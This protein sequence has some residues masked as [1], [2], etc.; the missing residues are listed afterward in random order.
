[1]FYLAAAELLTARAEISDAI[2]GY[3]CAFF[4]HSV[5]PIISACSCCCDLLLAPISRG[6]RR[7]LLRVISSER[8]CCFLCANQRRRGR[9]MEE[10]L[11]E[12][13]IAANSIWILR[14]QRAPGCWRKEACTFRVGS[15][16]HSISSA[17]QS[18]LYFIFHE[19]W[20][21]R[22]FDSDHLIV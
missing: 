8:S 5:L 9:M 22:M 13:Q 20:A 11:L 18:N 10:R 12:E 7:F 4:E 14:S 3:H 2:C 15:S 21:C 19:L 17:S 1:M 16:F 6:V